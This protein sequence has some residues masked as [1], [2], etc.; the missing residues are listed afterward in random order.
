MRDKRPVTDVVLELLPLDGSRVLH[1]ALEETIRHERI[2]GGLAALM[3]LCGDGRAVVETDGGHSFAR[4]VLA[5]VHRP[6]RRPVH[7]RRAR[8]QVAA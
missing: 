4:R 3:Q 6:V 5:D 1:L 2:K 8:T 7:L